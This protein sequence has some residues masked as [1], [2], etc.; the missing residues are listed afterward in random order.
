VRLAELQFIEKFRLSCLFLFCC[1][2]CALIT[3]QAVGPDGLG[4]HRWYHI[5]PTGIL[6][7][8]FGQNV[9]REDRQVFFVVAPDRFEALELKKN[10]RSCCHGDGRDAVSTV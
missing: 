1:R 8:D 9:L 6:A 10:V 5:S 4:N 2:G 3:E 7:L